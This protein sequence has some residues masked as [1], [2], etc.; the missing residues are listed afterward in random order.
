MDVWIQ[1]G[2]DFE[3]LQVWTGGGRLTPAVLAPSPL[4]EVGPEAPAPPLADPPVV[5]GAG[6]VPPTELLEEVPI[7]AQAASAA[8][9]LTKV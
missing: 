9:P 5:A 4:P 6:V 3:T 1:E 7:P 8:S 2:P